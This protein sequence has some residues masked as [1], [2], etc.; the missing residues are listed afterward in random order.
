[1]SECYCQGCLES[2]IATIELLLSDKLF[3]DSKDW[4]S[5]DTIDRIEYLIGMVKSQRED[6][7]NCYDMIER[8]EN[9]DVIHGEIPGR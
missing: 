9:P 7:A 1:M 6:L 4:M 2:K 5:S 8:H 3:P